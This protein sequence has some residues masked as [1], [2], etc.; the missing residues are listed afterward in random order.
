MLENSWYIRKPAIED[1]PRNV[2]KLT[3]HLWARDLAM[4]QPMWDIFA[5][6]VGRWVCKALAGALTKR[7]LLVM[8]KALGISCWDLE[9]YYTLLQQSIPF[10]W[11]KLHSL[12]LKVATCTVPFNA[13]DFLALEK[14]FSS[15][16]RRVLYFM[17]GYGKRNRWFSTPLGNVLQFSSDSCAETKDPYSPLQSSS[18][19]PQACLH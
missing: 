6:F 4:Y 11:K 10:A 19:T 12:V 13:M 16:L 7:C 15:L 18:T 17:P 8:E 5:T 2:V 1:V 14:L 3:S 9:M